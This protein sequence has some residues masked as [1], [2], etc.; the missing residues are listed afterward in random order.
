MKKTF[1]L[2]EVDCPACAERMAAAIR[3]L[4]GVTGAAINFVTQ[5]LTLETDDTAGEETIDAVRKT[6]ARMQRGCSIL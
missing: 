2:S 1:I 4:P 3:R 6:V 5:K